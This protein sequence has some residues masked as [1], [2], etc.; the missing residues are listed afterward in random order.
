M[1][2]TGCGGT[3]VNAVLDADMSGEAAGICVL[4]VLLLVAAAQWR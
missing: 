1:V 3:N 4:T 2:A